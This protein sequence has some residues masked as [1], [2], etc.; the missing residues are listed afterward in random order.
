M[1]TILPA[2]LHCYRPAPCPD[3]TLTHHT[4]LNF[5]QHI[6]Q[7]HTQVHGDVNNGKQHG[8]GTVVQ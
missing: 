8:H 4:T 5:A 3:L 2:A 1:H 7:E 6:N